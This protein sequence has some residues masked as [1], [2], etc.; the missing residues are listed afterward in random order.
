MKTDDY[1][2]IHLKPIQVKAVT[3]QKFDPQIW[4]CNNLHECLTLVRLKHQK[5]TVNGRQWILRFEYGSVI[6]GEFLI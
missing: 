1:T 2:P 5:F 3:P 4:K 6:A